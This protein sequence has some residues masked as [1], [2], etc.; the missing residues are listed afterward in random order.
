MIK[1]KMILP[2]AGMLGMLWTSSPQAAELSN[3]DAENIVRRSLQ[4]VALYDTLLNFTFNKKNP[5]A[6]GGWNKTHY[7][8][9]LMD[10]SVRAIP[11]PNND[12]LY[13]LSLLD[14]R[15]EPVII[16]Y[17]AFSS[18]FVSLETSALDH[19][20]D[21]PLAT[22]KG[23]FKKPTTFLYY[24]ARTEGYSGEP[25]RGVDKIMEMSGDYAVAFLRV[26]PEAK[27][28]EKFN[29]NMAAIQQVKLQTLSEFQGKPAKPA[30]PETIPAYGNDAQVFANNF[31]E[32]MQFVFNH[33]T[34]DPR[35]EMDQKALAAL[36]TVGVEP[37]K[38]YDA[39]QVPEIDGKQ[40]AAV[41]AEIAKKQLAIWN[42]PKAV[43]PFLFKVFLPKGHMDI[44][45]MVLQS[46]VGPIGQPADQAM[47][48]GIATADGK[49]M[50]AQYDYVI[51]MTKDELPPYT[52]FWSAT[53]YDTKH[54]FFIPNKQKKYSVG[55]NAGM[56]LNASG[57]IEI[58]IAAE[59]P[60]GVPAANWL[61][62]TREDLDLDVILRVYQP[63]L[64]KMKTW[65][66]PKAEKL[67]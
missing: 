27:D 5:F 29:A 8:Q 61:P 55:Q 28:P 37:D 67:K 14:L 25:V 52:A 43:A 56:K 31:Q 36:K 21:I 57:G 7:P 15:A 4:Y 6:A 9:G 12:T 26:M 23:D 59:Q 53:L 45:T 20:V 40:L 51:R 62:I 16:H 13:V 2:I 65:K 58:H 33:T 54:G 44:D 18:R 35:N 22:S 60:A 19:Y 10:A 1:I 39:D 46:A 47:Y 42:D 48:P 50:N 11:R 64:K 17:P 63:D 24:S 30:D 41:A 34:F 66:A 49:P 32:V 3:A 38:Q